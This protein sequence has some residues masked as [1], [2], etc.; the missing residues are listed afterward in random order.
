MKCG[1]YTIKDVG[2][3]VVAPGEQGCSDRFGARKV[4][5][6]CYP[7][8]CNPAH[9]VRKVI[10]QNPYSLHCVVSLGC[11]VVAVSSNFEI[12]ANLFRPFS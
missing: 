9:L 8:C 11:A 3:Y 6:F 12:H 5:K 4:R 7:K 1:E 2:L 10:C